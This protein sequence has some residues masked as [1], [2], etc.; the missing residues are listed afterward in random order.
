[1]AVW[2]DAMASSPPTLV[3]LMLALTWWLGVLGL[4][5]L[6]EQKQSLPWVGLP[7]VLVVH[8]RRWG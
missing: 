8:C 6:W 1:M 3:L 7:L 4:L 2:P 5:S